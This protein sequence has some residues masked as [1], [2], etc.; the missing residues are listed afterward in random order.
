MLSIFTYTLLFPVVSRQ[1]FYIALSTVLQN[2]LTC[3]KTMS[4]AQMNRDAIRRTITEL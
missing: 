3:F 1:G 2:I 4:F